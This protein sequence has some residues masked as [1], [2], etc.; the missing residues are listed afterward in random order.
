MFCQSC[1]KEI[2]DGSKFCKYCGAEVKGQSSS[3]Q[4]SSSSNDSGNDNSKKMIIGA[5]IVVIIVLA[6]IMGIFSLGLLDN[7]GGDA[8]AQASDNSAPAENKDPVSLDSFP[9][10]RA[11]ELAQVI[12]DSNGVFPVRFESLSLSKAQCSYI[13]T[14]S[15]SEIGNGHEDATIKV[16]NPQYASNPSGRDSS[17]SIAR[18]NYVDM[19]KRFSSWIESQGAVPNYV[20][21]YT[22]GVADVSPSRMMDIAVNVLLQYEDTGNLPSSVKI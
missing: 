7:N 12:K 10:S 20:G 13:L 17:Q 4:S 16:G 21:I 3:N 11:P 14:K 9:V 6:A 1:G 15:V 18:A 22:G 19:S 2:K 5:L 8:P